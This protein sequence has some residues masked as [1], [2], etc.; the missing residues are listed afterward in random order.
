MGHL[1]ESNQEKV[2]LK[3]LK[4]II[5]SLN[6]TSK[7][8]SDLVSKAYS[9]EVKIMPFGDRLILDV[10]IDNVIK[11]FH[12]AEI[13]LISDQRDGDIMKARRIYCA[14][15]YAMTGTSYSKIGNIVERDH[16]TVINA[17]K[18]IKNFR[19][20]GDVLYNDYIEIEKLVLDKLNKIKSERQ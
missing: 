8:I 6:N 1:V 9:L 18:K 14:M 2:F 11:Y 20:T 15:G 4:F 10:I 12:I 17:C 19:D 7:Q 13:D 5:D 3:E 16:A